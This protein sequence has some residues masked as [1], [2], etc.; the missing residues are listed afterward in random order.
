MITG[1]D[2]VYVIE[3]VQSDDL[4]DVFTCPGVFG[5]YVG[6]GDTVKG[7]AFFYLDAPVVF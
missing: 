4:I 7:V 2:A 5:G 6:S 1:M 3:A